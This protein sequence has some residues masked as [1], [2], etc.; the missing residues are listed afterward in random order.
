MLP[1]RWTKA[2][3]APLVLPPPP[4]LP[5]SCQISPEKKRKNPPV[6]L[7]RRGKFKKWKRPT[8][9]PNPLVEPWSKRRSQK[10]SNL[11]ALGMV[12]DPLDLVDLQHPI[13]LA[14]VMDNILLLNKFVQKNSSKL[15]P[16]KNLEEALSFLEDRIIEDIL[17]AQPSLDLVY[18]QHQL[19]QAFVMTNQSL[20][21]KFVRRNA[22]KLEPSKKLEQLRGKYGYIR[23]K[24]C[25]VKT[26]TLSHISEYYPKKDALVKFVKVEERRHNRSLSV[27]RKPAKVIGSRIE[28]TNYGNNMP[29]ELNFEKESC[30]FTCTSIFGVKYTLKYPID[31]IK[32][33]FLCY[34]LAC[35]RKE[36]T[37]PKRNEDFVP[38]FYLDQ[39]MWK[40]IHSFLK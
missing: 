8:S 36:M 22:S 11:Q 10:V 37:L 24:R 9:I 14:F 32:E 18:L 12:D 26:K 35:K 5:I 21:R 1:V 30:T 19:V 16:S 40:T 27:F 7:F 6:D 33:V 3:V 15:V 2:P 25:Y 31:Y 28:I 20:L 39:D 38:R 17:P 4:P 23:W 13:V 29:V 34:M